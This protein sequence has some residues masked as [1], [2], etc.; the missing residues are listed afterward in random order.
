MLVK[1]LNM[2]VKELRMLLSEFMMDAPNPDGSV[3]T[4]EEL[5]LM[6]EL[7]AR[8]DAGAEDD[9]TTGTGFGADFTVSVTVFFVGTTASVAHV[10]GTIPSESE[11]QRA[12]GGQSLGE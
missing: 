11:V 9:L 3:A 1:E 7:V 12:G 6:T 8:D 5:E 4:E 10:P 2:L